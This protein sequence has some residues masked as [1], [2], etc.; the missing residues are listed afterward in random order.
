MAP[1]VISENYV[2][3][4]SK[5]PSLSGEYFHSMTHEFIVPDDTTIYRIVET[6]YETADYDNIAVVYEL[7]F[8]SLDFIEGYINELRDDGAS[9]EEVVREVMQLGME[10]EEQSIIV[11]RFA[12]DSFSFLDQNQQQAAGKQI[13]G[14]FV[15]AQKSGAGL[16]G[17]I[18][19]QFVLIHGHLVCDNT[20]T[21]FGAALW[22]GTVRN[23]VGKVDI[24]DCVAQQYVQELGD[25]A[26]GVQGFIPWDLGT[27]TYPHTFK[28]TRWRKY[29]FEIKSCRHI[30]LIVSR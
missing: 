3:D 6:T 16:A 17:Q 2:K 9:D 25:L 14:A 27:V 13:R 28:M 23:V 18:Y 11:A 1:T 29:P 24:Y 30:V 26:T 8:H 22:A 10:N 15:D 12:Y 21:E 4:L 20:Q 19:R 7:T 5:A